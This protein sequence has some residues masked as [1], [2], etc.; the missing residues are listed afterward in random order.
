MH[1]LVISG[2]GRRTKVR[3][4]RLRPRSL[5][6]S[7]P[8]TNLWPSAGRIVRATSAVADPAASHALPSLP[9][10][11]RVDLCSRRRLEPPSVAN[12][13]FTSVLP[14]F[15]HRISSPCGIAREVPATRFADIRLRIRPTMF[16][17]IESRRTS[18][19]ASQSFRRQGPPAATPSLS[20]GKFLN[21]L[22]CERSD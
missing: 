19:P 18:R 21:G 3:V 1:A 4:V 14:T 6:G 22:W 15:I 11:Q 13:R 2:S 8:G 5:G 20:L 16:N 7:H 10:R 9:G 17:P 12:C